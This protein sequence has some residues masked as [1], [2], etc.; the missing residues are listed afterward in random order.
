MGAPRI[1]GIS[2]STVSPAELARRTRRHGLR[3]TEPIALGFLEDWRRQ[4]IAE[5]IDGRWRLTQT[6]RAMFGT[7]AT[8]I[9]LDDG[10]PSA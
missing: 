5:E 6:G 2:V 10:E 3:I 8:G 1:G 9:G 7:W 4:G